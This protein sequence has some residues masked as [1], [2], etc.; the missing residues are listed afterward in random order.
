MMGDFF[1]VDKFI[2]Q[3]MECKPLSEQEVKA[4]CDKVN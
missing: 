1:D 2:A 4:L 3:L